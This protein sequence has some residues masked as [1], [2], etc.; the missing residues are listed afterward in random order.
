MDRATSASAGWTS[1][2]RRGSPSCGSPPV[3]RSPGGT[4]PPASRPRT[5]APRRCAPWRAAVSRTDDHAAGCVGGGGGG[6]D[7]CAHAHL[8][9]RCEAFG[10]S[11]IARPLG[12]EW[13]ASAREHGDLPTVAELARLA[14]EEAH[15]HFPPPRVDALVAREA[16]IQ[17]DR[18]RMAAQRRRYR[19]RLPPERVLERPLGDLLPRG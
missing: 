2:L 7:R 16:G 9:E 13:S 5:P 10:Q 8:D 1:S 17:L 19:K 18:E 6:P 12:K 14:Q 11:Q 4:A 3:R 15:P